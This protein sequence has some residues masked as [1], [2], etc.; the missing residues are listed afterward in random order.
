MPCGWEGNCRS[1]V[2]LAMRHKLQW[3]IYLRVHDLD[4]EMSLHSLVEYSPFT[5]T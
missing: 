4:R 1:G 3:F 2:A 5:F